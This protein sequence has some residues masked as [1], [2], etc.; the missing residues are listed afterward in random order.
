M[1]DFTCTV[2]CSRTK[3]ID[4][5]A[6]VSLRSTHPTNPHPV[7]WVEER[8]PSPRCCGKSHHW[9]RSLDCLWERIHSRKKRPGNCPAFCRLAPITPC[10]EPPPKSATG[11]VPY[12]NGLR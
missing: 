11:S 1:P 3:P 4:P 7:G 10:N 6:W 8:N 12:G 9:L 2:P 5:T